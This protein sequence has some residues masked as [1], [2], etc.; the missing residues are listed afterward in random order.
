MPPSDPKR[1]YDIYTQLQKRGL[2]L[3]LSR[4]RLSDEMSLQE[5]SLQE[6]EDRALRVRMPAITKVPL[7]ELDD[8]ELDE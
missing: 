4:G 2:P 8:A 1:E 6:M 3:A 7:E 5:M